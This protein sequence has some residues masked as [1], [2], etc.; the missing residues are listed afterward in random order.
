MKNAKQNARE[1]RRR[2]SVTLG[3]CRARISHKGL[4]NRTMRT[5]QGQDSL[6]AC[7]GRRCPKQR[8]APIPDVHWR[9]ASGTR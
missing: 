1:T 9:K 4:V 7:M 2:K 5:K 8:E 6:M 3:Q